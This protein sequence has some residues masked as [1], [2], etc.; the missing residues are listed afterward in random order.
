MP[1]KQAATTT[2]PGTLSSQDNTS[3]GEASV[4]SQIVT[5]AQLKS[6]ISQIE[7]NIEALNKRLI[8]IGTLKIKLLTVKC[9]N[10]SCT[11]LKGYLIQILLKIKTKALKLAL[12]GDT[13]A[14]AGIFLTGRA[15]E[16]FKP[17]LLEY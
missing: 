11:G 2:T 10:G 12:A 1:P 8:E 3:I 15:L 14:Y 6:I 17:Y 5:I 7:G 13:I 9:Y 16:Q 4:D